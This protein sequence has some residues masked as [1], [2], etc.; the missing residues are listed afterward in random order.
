MM[1]PASIPCKIFEGAFSGEL[2]FEFLEANGSAYRSVAD[3]NYFTD[4]GGNKISNGYT[5]SGYIQGRI[6]KI[7]GDVAYISIPDGVVVAVKNQLLEGD[8]ADG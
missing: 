4:T 1:R 5:G 8:K 3:R 2:I 6:V 7:D